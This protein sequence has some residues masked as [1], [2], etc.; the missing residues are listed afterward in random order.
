MSG[1]DRGCIDFP[2]IGSGPT[3]SSLEQVMG[4]KNP[5]LEESAAFSQGV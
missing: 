5:F 4:L 2:Q 1:E 3:L